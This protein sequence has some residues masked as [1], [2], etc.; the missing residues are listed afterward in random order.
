[1][2][3]IA[4]QASEPRRGLELP[5]A[6]ASALQ[7]YFKNALHA[8]LVA[9]C[10]NAPLAAMAAILVAGPQQRQGM[11]AEL[12][13]Q[14]AQ[15]QKLHSKLVANRTRRFFSVADPDLEIIAEC[16]PMKLNMIIKMLDEA[17]WTPEFIA[18]FIAGLRKRDLEYSIALDSFDPLVFKRRYSKIF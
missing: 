18:S 5:Q 16:A 2:Y 15:Y 6:Q 1:M 3:A 9:S 7:T 17:Q 14:I 4:M 13:L 11:M 10:D 12:K 8:Y